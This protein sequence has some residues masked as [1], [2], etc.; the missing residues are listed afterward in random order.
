MRRGPFLDKGIDDSH[1]VVFADI[2]VKALWQQ[3]D[4]LS[5]PAFDESLHV[6]ALK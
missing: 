5:I 4:L 6:A 3:S 2:V 1:R